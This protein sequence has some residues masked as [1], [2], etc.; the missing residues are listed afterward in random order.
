MERHKAYSD[1]KLAHQTDESP[2][3]WC[4]KVTDKFLNVECG[5]DERDGVNEAEQCLDSTIY[6]TKYTIL[7]GWNTWVALIHEQASFK[8]NEL[9]IQEC[10]EKTGSLA[11]YR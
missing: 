1:D 4:G 11:S 2:G 9:Q 7:D 5:F 10:T 3:A 8:V 6:S